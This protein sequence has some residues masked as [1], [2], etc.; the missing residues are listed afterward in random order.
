MMLRQ[1]AV[2]RGQTVTAV[3]FIRTFVAVAT[4]IVGFAATVLIVL[5]LWL[6]ARDT[7][8]M[9][10]EISAPEELTDRGYTDSLIAHQILSEWKMIDATATTKKRRKEIGLSRGQVDLAMPGINLSVRSVADYFR[11]KFGLKQ[12][13]LRGG[14]V[15]VDSELPQCA[16][17]CYA[18]HVDLDGSTP[19]H[20]VVGPRPR[21]EIELLVREA[22]R[23]AVEFL[24]PYL[25]ANFYFSSKSE[26]EPT[27]ASEIDRL[28]DVTL[29]TK[30]AS[31]DPFALTLRGAMYNRQQNWAAAIVEFDRALDLDS[32]FASAI[33]SRCWAAAHIPGRTAE[34]IRD[35]RS[36]LRLDR[37]S[38]E[39]M[40]SLAFA[41][42]KD[43]QTEAAFLV[44]KCARQISD[45]APSVETTYARL[46]GAVPGASTKRPTREECASALDL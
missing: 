12:E 44:I 23:K 6:E 27:G 32:D 1:I 45:R 17:G 7:A 30:P 3:G 16:A 8:I 36:A 20:F 41:M 42:E 18:F 11:S 21:A 39:T 29:R 22:A 10:D 46:K 28:V 19:K 13:R 40:D 43:G 24:D 14:L 35:C 26:D 4:W 31:D 37:D 9:I 15:V 5:L 38:F 25:L 34:A 2:S 33:N